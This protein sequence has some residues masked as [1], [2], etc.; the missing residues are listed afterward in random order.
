MG[1]AQATNDIH[2]PIEAVWD[3]LNDIDHTPAWVEGLERAEVIT[4]PPYGVGTIYTDYNW[5]G[6]FLQVTNW[7]ITHFEPYAQQVHES[8]SRVLPSA[9]TMTLTAIPEGARLDMAV[10]Y[11]FLPRFGVVGRLLEKWVMNR[12]LAQVLKQNQVNLNVY[13]RHMD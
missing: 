3:A 7:Q 2:A 5:L 8:Q 13:L 1:Y 11:R 12:L 6:P 9:M 4:P 10:N